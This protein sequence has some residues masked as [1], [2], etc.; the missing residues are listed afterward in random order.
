M[1]G[2]AWRIAAVVC[3]LLVIAGCGDGGG[4]RVSSGSDGNIAAPGGVPVESVPG[5]PTG[6]PTG[7]QG[8]VT[9]PAGEP[10]ATASVVRAP[11]DSTAAV[12]QEAAVTDADGRYFW[13]LPPG[14]WEITIS[15]P[16]LRTASRRV[17]VV[18]GQ[19]ARLDFALQ[20]G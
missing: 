9:N 12:T 1:V 7:V 16:G 5:V 2:V 11:V 14:T 10:V 13:P 8:R 3:L 6:V 19:R 20:A 15:A 17:T 4:A 18:D